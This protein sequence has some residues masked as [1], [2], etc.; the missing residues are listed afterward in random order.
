MTE[1]LV[2]VLEST[3]SVT[4]VQRRFSTSV[5]EIGRFRWSKVIAAPR[6]VGSVV[7]SVLRR[8]P[9][10]AILFVT[11]RPFSFVVDVAVATALRLLGV[12]TVF[13]IHTRGFTT[14]AE[15]GRV[16]RVAAEF[17]F[18]CAAGVVT[19]TDSMVT[20]VRSLTSRPIWVIPNSPDIRAADSRERRD[21]DQYILYLSNYLEEKGALD[22]IKAV[23]LAQGKRPSL[24]LKLHGAGGS[25]DFHERL[26]QA[27][28]ACP[29]PEQ[30][31]IGGPLDRD[32][33]WGVL[34][35]SLMLLFP[36]T[37]AF[38]AQPL[39]IIEALSSGVPVVAYDVGSIPDL[40]PPAAGRLAP[41]G[42]VTELS[43]RLVELV[44]TNGPSGAY[45]RGARAQYEQVHSRAAY[46]ENWKI[47][48]DAVTAL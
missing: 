17:L 16:W 43:E 35:G 38:E 48:L 47:V 37:Y 15:K 24:S 11:N 10:V 12:R 27:R 41:P 21:D 23:G 22:A 33:K 42:S 31:Q 2:A 18:C 46:A 3:H 25:L 26:M 4:T 9:H 5:D 36:S 14:L 1:V 8:R 6:L 34:Q 45:S 28:E 30:I 19:L 7:S 40:V 20:D 44:D 13:Y 32:Q 29:F 39:V